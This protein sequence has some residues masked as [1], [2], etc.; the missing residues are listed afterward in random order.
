V[1]FAIA[2]PRS[3]ITR[4]NHINHPPTTTH[5]RFKRV[6]GQS[7]TFIGHSQTLVGQ[8]WTLYPTHIDVNF[9][10]LGGCMGHRTGLHTDIQAPFY[11]RGKNFQI[12]TLRKGKAVYPAMVCVCVDL[13]I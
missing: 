2:T 5:N 1:K 10:I 13:K 3:Y 6:N 8:N 7:W 4:T 9:Y 11:T 12:K